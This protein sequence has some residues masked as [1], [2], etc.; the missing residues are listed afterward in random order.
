MSERKNNDP[1]LRT[2]KIK[3]IEEEDILGNEQ[4]LDP[5]DAP[6]NVQKAKMH[7]RASLIFDYEKLEKNKV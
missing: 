5:E 7:H 2:E 1:E 6:G 4:Y 3:K